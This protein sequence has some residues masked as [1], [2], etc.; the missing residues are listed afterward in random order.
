MTYLDWLLPM[1]SDDYI[2]TW[3]CKIKWQTKIMIYPLIHCLWLSILAEDIQC[4]VPFHEVTGSFDHVVLQIH[5]KYFR[6]CITTAIRTLLNLT[7]WRLTIR[8]FNPLSHIT[9]WRSGHVKSR[10][11][12]KTFYLYYHDTYGPQTWQGGYMQWG[13][14]FHSVSWP[15]D[16]VVWWFFLYDL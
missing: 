10:N 6:C 12:L 5:V 15:F 1:K 7:R 16:H 8:I 9:L 11:K 14:S 13:V 4:G 2:I 3:S